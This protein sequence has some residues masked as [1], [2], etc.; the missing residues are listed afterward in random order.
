MPNFVDPVK[1][2]GT[3]FID[4]SGNVAARMIV[5]A[6]KTSVGASQADVEI[7][8]FTAPV[9]LT[10]VGVQ[11]YCTA[12]AAAASVNVK[13]AG[14]SVLSSA[15]TPT[16]NAVANGTI[17]DSSIA[18]GAAVTVR[19]TTDATGSISDLTVTLIFKVVAS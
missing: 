6:H 14:V 7:F 12:T 10:L 11:V 2:N 3:T 19:V 8:E 18:S 4:E 16:A 15:V 1:V 5:Q 17:S 13:E 9:A